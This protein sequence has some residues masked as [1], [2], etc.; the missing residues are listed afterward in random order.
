M[1]RT[2]NSAVVCCPFCCP[3]S[4]YFQTP[5]LPTAA[6]GKKRPHFQGGSSEAMRRSISRTEKH[7]IIPPPKIK[8]LLL[9]LFFLLLVIIVSGCLMVVRWL[10]DGGLMVARWR[11]GLSGYAVNIAAAWL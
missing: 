3:F 10:C 5:S 1:V 8:Q 6:F 2:Q 9:L 7:K 11:S 4:R